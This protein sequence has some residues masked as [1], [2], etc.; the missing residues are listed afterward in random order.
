MDQWRERLHATR[1]LFLEDDEEDDFNVNWII[2]LG[3]SDPRGQIPSIV[4]GSRPGKSPNIDR[5]RHEMHARMMSD[6]F[7]DE[8]V[9]GPNFFRRRYRIRRSLFFTILDR[10]C[11]RDDYFVQKIDACGFLGLSPH[12]KITS[13]LRMLC[14]GLC[15]D[16]TDE[17][18]RTSETTAMTSM[19]RF[20]IAIRAEFEAYHM[21]QP[22]R[23]DFDK[24]LAINVDRGFP[25][26]F[27]SLDCM[28]Y[29][30][31]NCPVAWQG[32]FGDKDG[33]KSIILEAMADGGLHIWHAF[34][35]LPGSNN[36]LNVL[37]R[38]PLIHNMLTSEARDMQFE[39]NGCHYDRYYLLTDGI[40][41]EWSCFVQSIHQ[42]QDEKRSYFAE[43]QEAVRKDVERCFGV[44]QARF[45][46]IRN[47]CRHWSMDVISNIMFT[48]CILHNMIIDDEEGVE[49][50]DDIIGELHEGNIPMQRGLSFDEFMASTMD[51]AN[52]DTHFGLRGDLIE[53]LWMLKGAN[54]A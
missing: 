2:G 19:K 47:P 35:G 37:D 36:D 50:L 7:A 46:I 30:W 14:Y 29:E 8:P 16:A 34:F 1:E 48:C 33:K 49:G 41:P 42:P 3:L 43:R 52:A 40:Y 22:T 38:S 54:L 32:D 45:A 53:H 4:R 51:I 18:C 27:A 6:Y 23:A 44:L 12:Q 13:A 9:Y 39:V 10:V 15:A 11:A 24:Q 5:H 20:C 28:H 17:Y 25:G 31:K 26:M 21:R